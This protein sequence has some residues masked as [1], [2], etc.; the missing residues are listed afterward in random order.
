MQKLTIPVA[1]LHGDY[2]WVERKTGDDL[3]TK[4]HIEGEVFTVQN[5]GHHLYIEGSYECSFN[6]VSF[7]FGEEIANHMMAKFN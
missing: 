3:L 7:C 1:F 5:S 2:D 4:G 6:I